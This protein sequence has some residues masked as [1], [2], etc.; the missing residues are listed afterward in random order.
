MINP[1]KSSFHI[2]P[3]HNR[4][5]FRCNVCGVSDIP[6]RT[7]TLYGAVGGYRIMKMTYIYRVCGDSMFH[8]TT[9]THLLSCMASYVKWPKFSSPVWKI[10]SI[11][12]KISKLHQ[13]FVGPDSSVGI[14]TC[15]GL[16]GP[17][18]DP[19][20]GEI[21]HNPPD[22]PWVPPSLR[23]NGYLVFPGGKE[24]LTTHLIYQRGSRKGRGIP[25]LP[26]GPSWPVLGWT[27]TLLYTSS[28]ALNDEFYLLNL[29]DAV[30][31]LCYL[32]TS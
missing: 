1:A 28:V 3:T 11:H 26:P 24:A 27:L 6:V 31:S 9:G 5:T 13:Q 25:L 17:G 12:L 20:W 16:D 10:Y 8:Q 19:G 21:F 14:A 22:R 23:Y 18:I 30:T 29:L 32:G 7:Q 4:A 2:F 15:Y